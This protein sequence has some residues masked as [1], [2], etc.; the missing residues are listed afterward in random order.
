MNVLF[1][2]TAHYPLW[3]AA[4]ASDTRHRI[5]PQPMA[6]AITARR[7][8]HTAGAALAAMVGRRL[9]TVGRTADHQLTPTHTAA[10]F[11]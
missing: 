10:D 8:G 4:I 9:R 2:T 1:K 7:T 6:T 11:V 3:L 5:S